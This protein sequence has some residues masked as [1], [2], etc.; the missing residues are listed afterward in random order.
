LLL[1]IFAHF[2]NKLAQFIKDTQYMV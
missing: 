2:T 1:K